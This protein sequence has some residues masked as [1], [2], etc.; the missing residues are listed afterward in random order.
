VQRP[1]AAL[2]PP[3]AGLRLDAVIHRRLAAFIRR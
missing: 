3:H 2:L 1:A